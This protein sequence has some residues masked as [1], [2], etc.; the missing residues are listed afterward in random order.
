MQISAEEK[1]MLKEI[2]YGI[3]ANLSDAQHP[4][5][6]GVICD[7][8]IK[9]YIQNAGKLIGKLEYLLIYKEESAIKES[10]ASE[11]PAA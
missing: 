1:E 2:F 9:E 8:R 3:G 6:L 5:T 7:P 4:P 11:K 10:A